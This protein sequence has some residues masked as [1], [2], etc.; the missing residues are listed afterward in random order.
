M[1]HMARCNM[2]LVKIR[3]ER[4]LNQG[5][6]A[7]QIGISRSYYNQIENGTRT[8]SLPV[9]QAIARFFGKPI[10]DLFPIDQRDVTREFSP[11]SQQ[12]DKPAATVAQ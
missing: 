10:D 5:E 6:V 1:S 11:P 4:D 12:S 7:E 3:T 8:P 9:C 2:A